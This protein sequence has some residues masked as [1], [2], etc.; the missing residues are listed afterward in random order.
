MILAE[1]KE[2]YH[3]VSCSGPFTVLKVGYTYIFLGSHSCI[4]VKKTYRRLASGLQQ[5]G[6]QFPS[7]SWHIPR[8][9]GYRQLL[10]RSLL[11]SRDQGFLGA[12]EVNNKLVSSHGK[13]K[14]GSGSGSG[15][16]QGGDSVDNRSRRRTRSGSGGS[17]SASNSR[18]WS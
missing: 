15:G 12:R 10:K 5:L 13:A 8:S 17:F 9:L 16:G 2:T 1:L 3:E 18:I 6:P 11:G 14:Q 7:C 4:T